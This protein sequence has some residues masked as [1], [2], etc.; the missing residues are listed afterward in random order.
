[1]DVTFTK[2]E[3]AAVFELIDQLSGGNPASGFSW[4]GKDD[5]KEPTTSALVKIFK[6]VGRDVPENLE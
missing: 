4:D 2:E 1:M 6:S 5:P 3:V